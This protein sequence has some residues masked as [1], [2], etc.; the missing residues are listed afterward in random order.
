MRRQTSAA[1]SGAP[2]RTPSLHALAEAPGA[3]GEACGLVARHVPGAQLAVRSAAELSF[4]LP[5]ERAAACAP[6]RPRTPVTGAV[7][8]SR[9]GPVL[10][11]DF[12]SAGSIEVRC[13]TSTHL[14]DS[15]QF[16]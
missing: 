14:S 13:Q 1:G 10:Q 2:S 11:I 4:R 5:R 12:R 3:E 16:P 7:C 6:T 15:V 8:Q 9:Q